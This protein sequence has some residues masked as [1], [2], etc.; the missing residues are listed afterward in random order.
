MKLKQL[1]TLSV[2]DCHALTGLEN[3]INSLPDLEKVNT[4]NYNFEEGY[5]KNMKT[6][7]PTLEINNWM[8]SCIIH[9]TMD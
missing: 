5:I 7:R 6:T 1:R 2:T 4:K 9:S 3:I 8:S